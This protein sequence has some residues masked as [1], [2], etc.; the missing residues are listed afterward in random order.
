ML[1][2]SAQ[3]KSCSISH[4]CSSSHSLSCGVW[5][6]RSSSRLGWA[7][8]ST[9]IFVSMA[10]PITRVKVEGGL[11]FENLTVWTYSS[12]LEREST[13][14][15][16]PGD[17]FTYIVFLGAFILVS[18]SKYMLFPSPR[19]YI[20]PLIFSYV[21]EIIIHLAYLPAQPTPLAE[22][23]PGN[24]GNYPCI[25]AGPSFAVNPKGS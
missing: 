25:L 12:G 9:R 17:F 7:S 15:S 6:P 2:S 4:G 8:F 11:I 23:V 21:H 3:N 13:R 10:I 16:Q 20:F 24:E 1:A 18:N 22:A 14:F 5:S 19:F